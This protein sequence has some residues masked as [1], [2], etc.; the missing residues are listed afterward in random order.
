M[1]FTFVVSKAKHGSLPVSI[2]GS[3]RQG[4]EIHYRHYL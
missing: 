3:Q 4:N 1:L 2:M